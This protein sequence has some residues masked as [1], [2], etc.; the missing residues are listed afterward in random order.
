MFSHNICHV[1][2]IFSIFS[3]FEYGISLLCLCSSTCLLGVVFLKI[4]S[5]LSDFKVLCH[6][7]YFIIL[8]ILQ[9]LVLF[10]CLN[11]NLITRIGL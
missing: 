7:L 3:G 4:P 5:P 6:L 10:S 9:R 1:F 8:G 11:Y 2:G